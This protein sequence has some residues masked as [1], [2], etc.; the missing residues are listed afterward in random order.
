MTVGG[1][2]TSGG[3]RFAHVL[4]DRD[5]L[6]RLLLDYRDANRRSS[7]YGLAFADNLVHD[8]PKR[9]HVDFIQIGA[10]GTAAA[11]LW[12]SWHPG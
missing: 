4:T 6:A 11:R 9:I 5:P 2:A 12:M 3:E 8:A 7:T 1:G 10:A